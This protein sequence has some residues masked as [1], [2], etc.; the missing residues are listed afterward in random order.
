MRRQFQQQSGMSFASTVNDMASRSGAAVGDMSTA[1]VVK[2]E[3]AAKQVNHFKVMFMNVF[4]SSGK[5][6]TKLDIMV[7]VLMG[8]S[9]ACAVL[10]RRPG[11]A[12]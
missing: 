9:R 4:R 2:K 6:T 10:D 11:A 1:D 12:E 3:S 7:P 8:M 5:L